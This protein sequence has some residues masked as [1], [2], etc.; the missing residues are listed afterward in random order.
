MNIGEAAKNSG[1]SAK[2][3]RYYEETGLIPQAMRTESGYR[4]YS[5]QD[6]HMLRFIRRARDLG[7]TVSG[8][9]ELLGLWRDRSRHSADVKRLALAHVAEL[10]QKIRELDDMA[11]TLESLAAHCQ[12]NDR[13]DCPILSDLERAPS[14][15]LDAWGQKVGRGC[16]SISQRNDPL[17][18]TGQTTMACSHFINP[19]LVPN[20][21]P[22]VSSRFAGGF[23]LR[24]VPKAASGVVD[25][26]F[27]QALH[28]PAVR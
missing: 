23:R 28:G 26:L 13:P 19:E 3:I 17:T 16:R 10:R 20:K 11:G 2:M 12:G 9:E 14:D 15:S 1:V 7:F 18:R 8:I 5:E 21:Q 25:R 24:A 6:V 27:C 4:V 22:K